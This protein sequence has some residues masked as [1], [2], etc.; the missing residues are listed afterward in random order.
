MSEYYKYIPFAPS[1]Y[2]YLDTV[3]DKHF[4][5]KKLIDG[6]IRINLYQNTSEPIRVDKTDFLYDV[7]VISGV[8][9]GECSILNPVITI[10]YIGIPNFNYVY[11]EAFNRY[12]YVDNVT[13]YNNNLYEISLSVDVLMTYKTGILQLRGFVDRCE[14]EYDETIIDPKRVIKSG[15]FIDTITVESFAF[16]PIDIDNTYYEPVTLALSGNAVKVTGEGIG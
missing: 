14:S 7:G 4:Y 8:L 6:A 9:R 5:V 3:D 12:Y 11:I 1:N 10:E 15:S 2:D 13:I 16:K